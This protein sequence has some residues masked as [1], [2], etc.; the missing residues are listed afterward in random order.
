LMIT[1]KWK[2]FSVDGRLHD[3]IKPTILVLL[4]YGLMALVYCVPWVCDNILFLTIFPWQY[5]AG[6]ALLTAVW[7][8]VT[9]TILRNARFA[10][11]NGAVEGW[12]DRKLNKAYG[13]K[14]T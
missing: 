7:F 6:L 5:F 9:R 10:R 1:P 8:L 3:D 14:G 13:R 2:F 12:F 4:L 11:I